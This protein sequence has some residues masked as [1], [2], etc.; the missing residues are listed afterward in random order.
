MDSTVAPFLIRFPLNA[1]LPTEATSAV[2]VASTITHGQNTISM[3]IARIRSPLHHQS[4]PPKTI[5]VG[6]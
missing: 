2:G 1:A 5:A 3:V 4:K 6:V